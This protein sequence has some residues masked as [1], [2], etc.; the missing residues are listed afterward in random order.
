[1]NIATRVEETK[2]RHEEGTVKL[3]MIVPVFLTV[4]LLIY[5]ICAL[6]RGADL[7]GTAS[8]IGAIGGVVTACNWT[9]R[10]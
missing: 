8:V 10:W 6:G 5:A 9:V 2:P 4:A 1:M 7:L 3:G